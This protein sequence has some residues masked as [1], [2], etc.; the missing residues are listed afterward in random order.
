MPHQPATAGVVGAAAASQ[1]PRANAAS[2]AKDSST[3]PTVQIAA[4]ELQQTTNSADLQQV[5]AA[6]INAAL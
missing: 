6:A 5:M 4:Q 1:T 2:R 3:E